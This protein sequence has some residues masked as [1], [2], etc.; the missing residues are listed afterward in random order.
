MKI[1][2]VL[3]I[4]CILAALGSAMY[5]LI[6]HRGASDRTV[7][8][9]TLRVAL[10]VALFMLLMLAYRLGWIQPHGVQ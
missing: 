2:A 6:R 4:L 8:A 9:L 5:S 7:K 1:I 3:L 10:S